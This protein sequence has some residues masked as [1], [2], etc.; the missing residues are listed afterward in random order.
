MVDSGMPVIITPGRKDMAVNAEEGF[1]IPSISTVPGKPHLKLV[2]KVEKPAEITADTLAAA[3]DSVAT[4]VDSVAIEEPYTDS[5]GV[6]PEETD[7]VATD[8]PETPPLR[9]H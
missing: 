6:M 5:L 4:P 2:A 8:K 1:E 7:T 3:N 9:E